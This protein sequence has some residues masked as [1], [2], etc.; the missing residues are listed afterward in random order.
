MTT[1]PVDPPATAPRLPAIVDQATWQAASDRL[2]VREKAHTRESDALAAARR[3]LP[4]VE[5]DGTTPVVGPAGPVPFR[6]LFHGRDELMVYKHMWHDGAPHQGQCEG[7]TVSAWHLRDAV[8]LNARGVSFAIVT[9]GPW[10]LYALQTSTSWATRSPG[11]RSATSRRRSVTTWGRSPASC[12]TATASS[13]RTPTT[14]RGVEA[15]TRALRPPR[16]GRPTAAARPGRTPPTGWPGGQ[17]PVLV[18]AHGHGPTPGRGPDQSTRAPVDPPRRDTRA[19]AGPAGPPP[20]TGSA[21]PSGPVRSRVRRTQVARQAS[22]AHDR[23]VG[24][25]RPARWAPARRRPSSRRPRRSAAATPPAARRRRP[26]RAGRRARIMNAASTSDARMPTSSRSPSRTTCDGSRRSAAARS[27]PAGSGRGPGA[28]LP[29]K[30]PDRD[31]QLADHVREPAVRAER[32]VPRALP[33]GRAAATRP[34]PGGRPRGGSGGSRRCPGRPPA[35]TR[36]SGRGSRSARAA[37]PAGPR[38]DPSRRA[39]T[40]APGRAT[41]TRPPRPAAGRRACPTVVGDQERRPCVEHQ[42][43]R[44]RT[45]RRDRRP[46]HERVAHDVERADRA[47]RLLVRR[48]QDGAVQ[49]RGS[50]ATASRPPGGRCQR[51]RGQIEVDPPDP[52]PLPTGVPAPAAVGADPQGCLLRAHGHGAYGRRGGPSRGR[53][54]PPSPPPPTLGAPA[55]AG[56]RPSI[57]SQTRTVRR[58]PGVPP[59]TRCSDVAGSTAYSRGSTGGSGVR[60]R[61]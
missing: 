5:L 10:D 6:D 29:R 18:L 15:V 58:R 21:P 51:S 43:A 17:R 53:P 4:M 16:P 32:Q 13:S 56:R 36:R 38:R 31:V 20:L 2:L 61:R 47:V 28:A 19:D 1:T 44:V 39:R 27:S 42:V 52:L 48:V 41:R 23:A 59:T 3:R 35:R 54:P 24:G 7:C 33:G 25:E 50:S 60:W 57:L 8:Y 46:V 30:H 34:R 37:T 22:G 14:G 11:T 12:A 45:P 40:P 49:R 55:S 9:T 26:G